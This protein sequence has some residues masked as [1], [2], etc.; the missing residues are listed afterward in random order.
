MAAAL[1]LSGI[2]RR[3]H[4]HYPA[5]LWEACVWR[6]SPSASSVGP[7][8]EPG[9]VGRAA[10]PT[11]A[12]RPGGGRGRSRPRPVGPSSPPGR[13]AW[14]PA[15]AIGS[16]GRPGPGRDRDAQ[17]ARI[18]G[19]ALRDLAR[20]LGGRAGQRPPAPRRDR[21]SYIL[22]HSG[23]AVAVTDA[24]HAGDVE[25]LVGTIASLKAA[26]LAPGE[27]WDRLTA[28]S[29]APLAGRRPQDPAWLFYT[30]GTTG[31]PKGATLTHRSLLMATLSYFADIEPVRAR[32][33][34]RHAAPLS[35]GAGPISTRRAWNTSP[36]SKGPRTTGSSR[37][38]G[39]QLRQGGQAGAAGP[40][41]S[42]NGGRR[43]AV[44][45]GPG[46]PPP[47]STKDAEYPHR[48]ETVS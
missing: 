46:G 18:P 1:L 14:R 9:R 42:R 10:R 17:P 21:L 47:S 15:C 5:L 45:P 43:I 44:R 38:A 11:A 28:S 8:D 27:H 34:V 7:C 3:R 39:Q 48:E 24:E 23:S 32:D 4:R 20:R 13:P 36:G 2:E 29:P 22:D 6:I 35:H 25:P 19:G 41:P 16:A 26:V 31:R 37:P 40:A 30:S 12:R 33:C